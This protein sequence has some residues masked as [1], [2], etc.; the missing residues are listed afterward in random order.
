M[1][2]QHN[3]FQHNAF[4][5]ALPGG[6][7]AQAEDYGTLVAAPQRADGAREFAG[8]GIM[9]GAVAALLVATQPVP[10]S[11]AE[12]TVGTHQ[13]AYAGE[14]RSF[15]LRG[16]PA[17][18]AVGQPPISQVIRA[19]EQI[20]SG[21]SLVFGREPEAL[22]TVVLKPIVS[23]PEQINSGDAWTVG[24]TPETA[25]TVVVS[26]K[27]AKPQ[28]FDDSSAQTFDYLYPSVIA[29]DVKQ[30]T[31]IRAAP[32]QIDDSQAE[33]W[34]P[35]NVQPPDP[36]GGV[37]YTVGTH[38]DYYAQNNGYSVKFGKY[39]VAE[40]V[41]T[42]VR[43][44][45]TLSAA[46]QQ[47]DDSRAEVYGFTE[48]VAAVPD[49]KKPKTLVSAPE[50]IDSGYARLSRYSY[51]AIWAITRYYEVSQDDTTQP[52]SA[53][54]G[55]TPSAA[56]AVRG[57][58]TWI[59]APQQVDSGSAWL[60]KYVYPFVAGVDAP[61]PKTVIAAPEQIN[62]GEVLVLGGQPPDVKQPSTWTAA[63]EQINS[64]DAWT[65]GIF[66]DE[67]F[68]AD[69]RIGT[70]L[71]SAELSQQPIEYG[72][73]FRPSAELIPP[74]VVPPAV[75]PPRGGDDRI[76]RKSPHRGYGT[77]RATLKRDEEQRAL[78][79]IRAIYRELTGHPEI[80]QRAEAVLADIQPQGESESAYAEYQARKQ[81]LTEQKL[82]SLAALGVES[83]IALRMLYVEM[84]EMLE[85]DD[86]QAI[87]LI[88]A[89]LL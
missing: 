50:Q 82:E 8:Y 84:R 45:Y 55:F 15:V 29:P 2:L 64:G 40:V 41:G 33:V 11:A 85:R 22:A 37:N 65:W 78:A 5:T 54:W 26:L 7:A 13:A 39:V 12:Y 56:P 10:I 48:S 4:Q 21:Y 17:L 32:E 3:A 31:T 83:E 28:D 73:A 20:D 87:A 57:P 1:S 60:T 18:F 43:G 9:F 59:A 89:Q 61:S 19:P 86:E 36:I 30:P 47:I 35:F 74:P 70:F 44:P 77:E 71:V 75:E 53:I 66:Q 88:L 6:A 58:R 14:N 67:V 38:G 72:L 52:G 69:T 49:V 62:S 68:G 34:S 79:E 25:S 63:P 42:D 16:S 46:P 76:R 80:A 27:T 23:A 81:A 24:P 51:P